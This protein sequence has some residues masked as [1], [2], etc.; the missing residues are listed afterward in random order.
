MDLLASVGS[1]WHCKHAPDAKAIYATVQRFAVNTLLLF[2]E[3]QYFVE[4][5]KS[6]DCTYEVPQVEG[7]RVAIKE[8]PLS[9]PI[10][11]CVVL[12]WKEILILITVFDT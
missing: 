11:V 1:I 6:Y 5:S 7:N 4:N 10:S 2:F 3:R 12:M 8:S 9:L